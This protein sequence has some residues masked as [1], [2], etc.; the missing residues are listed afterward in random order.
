MWMEYEE[1]AEAVKKRMEEE[2]GEGGSVSVCS[3]EKIN[4]TH[5]EGLE[6][7]EEGCQAGAIFRL[8]GLYAA[9]QKSGMEHTVSYILELLEKRPHPAS[10]D[11][12][13]EWEAVKGRIRLTLLNAGWNRELLEGCPNREL[14]DLAAAYCLELE[15]TD[16]RATALIKEYYLE[17]WGVTE[18]E[19][20]ETALENLQGEEYG[21]K[22]LT[23]ILESML[24]P[25]MGG[26]H[27]FPLLYVLTNQR[28]SHG[29][30]GILRKDLLE[31]FSKQIG[32]NFYILPS[33]VHETLLLADGPD[34]KAGELREMVQS[35]N[36]EEVSREEWLSENVY[37]YDR[38]AGEIEIAL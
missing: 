11:I 29:A 27:D 9:Y 21:I 14:L 35:I 20:W 26:F 2:I 22:P 1:F 6:I 34:I 18:G 7:K 15:D 37:Y 10:W 3:M 25:G 8:R 24:G 30:V 31:G 33:S 4:Q 16:C 23:E 12:P 32:G 19:L 28:V 5:W 38:E 17:S 36:R 13:G